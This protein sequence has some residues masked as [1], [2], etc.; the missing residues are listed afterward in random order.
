MK[1]PFKQLVNKE[2]RKL[3]LEEVEKDLKKHIVMWE[4]NVR[5]GERILLSAKEGQ[6]IEINTKIKQGKDTQNE[7]EQKL[8][9]V[10]DMLKEE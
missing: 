7:L 3:A 8:E 1:N 2:E 9:L 6:R 10:S 4:V 5:H